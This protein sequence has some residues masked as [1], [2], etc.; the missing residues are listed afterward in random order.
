MIAV[1]A[2]AII[3]PVMSVQMLRLLS[4][5]DEAEERL[6]V[7]SN[8]DDLTQT[9]NRRY[10]MQFGEQELKRAQRYG[11][12]FSIAL[13]DMDNFKLINDQCGHLMGDQVLRELSRLFR[14]QIR[15]T[16]VFARYGG[17]EF[18]F[19]FPKTSKR[20]TQSW[21]ERIYESFAGMSVNFEGLQVQ[22][23]FSMGIASFDSTT[24]DLDDLLKSADFALYDAKKSGGNKFVFM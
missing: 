23:S 16:D 10:F 14:E 1:L 4:H 8:I 15:E 24:R 9:Y 12:S 5:L 22:P 21:V 3:A 18:I 6:Q 20:E 2:P 7:L 11:E 17:D 13:L 19:L